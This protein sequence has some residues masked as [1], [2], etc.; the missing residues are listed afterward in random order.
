MPAGFAFVTLRDHGPS[1]LDV[2]LLVALA[3]PNDVHHVQA[4]RWFGAR[5]PLGWAPCS[6]VE[7]GFVRVSSNARALPAV[8][9]ADSAVE[10]VPV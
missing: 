10:L 3:W 9:Q 2:N 7:P 8:V 1:T 6:I 4:H 5:R